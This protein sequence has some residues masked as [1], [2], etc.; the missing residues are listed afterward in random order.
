MI[1][2][3]LAA[4]AAAILAAVG[5]GAAHAI[6]AHATSCTPSS[7][8]TTSTS[9]AGSK[10][11][12]EVAFAYEEQSDGHGGCDI[13]YAVQY[14]GGPDSNG[15]IANPMNGNI[16]IW[17]CGD[18]SGAIPG[19]ADAS[20]SETFTSTPPLQTDTSEFTHG[21]YGTMTAVTYS[22]WIDYYVNG[23]QCGPQIDDAYDS[24][25]DDPHGEWS[26]WLN[27]TLDGYGLFPYA[28]I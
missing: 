28:H 13:Q 23:T 11:G 3:I 21:A 1:R 15:I 9:V 7:W 22:G 18:D 17:V 20:W 5:M 19:G 6:T 4:G 12:G 27:G 26:S 25:S 2:R 14:F 24:N 8:T 10:P 16:R